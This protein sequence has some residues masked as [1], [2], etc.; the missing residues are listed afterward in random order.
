M[1]LIE[2]ASV[3]LHARD[4]AHVIPLNYETFIE[5][6]RYDKKNRKFFL[7]F[8]NRI[9]DSSR[10][11]YNKSILTLTPNPLAPIPIAMLVDTDCYDGTNPE[12]TVNGPI[13][14]AEYT[15]ANFFSED[16]ILDEFPYP[17]RTSIAEEI[18]DNPRDTGGTIYRYYY[19]TSDGD[20]GYR[21]ATVSYVTLNDIE[22]TFTNLDDNVYQDYA[23]RLIPR[24]AA[25]SNGLLEYFFRGRMDVNAVPLFEDM[26][27]IQNQLYMLIVKIKNTTP[28]EAMKDGTFE[29]HYKMEGGQYGSALCGT[30][31]CAGDCTQKVPSGT[32]NEN[33]EKVIQFYLPTDN[34]I[35]IDNFQTVKWTLVFKGTL[36]LEKDNAIVAKVFPLQDEIEAG[37]GNK[38]FN[39]EWEAENDINGYPWNNWYHGA[40]WFYAGG[41]GGRI[42]NQSTGSLDMRLVRLKNAYGEYPVSCGS[43][44][45]DLHLQIS[46][47]SWIQFKNYTEYL[48][49][50]KNADGKDIQLQWLQLGFS[51][52]WYI[53][54][55]DNAT[56]DW[57]DGAYKSQTLYY[58]FNPGGIILNNIYSIFEDN[59]IPVTETLYLEEITFMQDMYELLNPQTEDLFMR[60]LS[61]Y[62]RIIDT[63][64]NFD[65]CQG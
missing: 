3:P 59:G 51:N 48:N 30:V 28:N 63:G 37:W 31:G 15:N 34:P 32:L 21:L 22:T 62:I 53:V 60:L 36:G 58:V 26:N 23:D 55:L 64:P 61:D 2:D 16:T 10:Y 11:N 4:D 41:S 54:F 13:G 7:G 38:K 47:S 9:K 24:A 19:K 52:G 18:I 49:Y 14:L 43:G 65:F 1:H 40:C 50:Q 17:S 25:Y 42:Y 44:T 29:L 45:R 5:R 20:T 12:D 39:E 33:G 35:T 27:G 8:L 6:T 57:P 56:G 46:P